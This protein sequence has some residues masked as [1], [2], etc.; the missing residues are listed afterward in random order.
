MTMRRSNSWGLVVMMAIACGGDDDSGTS[1]ATAAT[2]TG[3]ESSSGPATT[4]ESTNGTTNATTVGT[5][6]GTTM[7]DD[8]PAD[9]G[10]GDT[11]PADTGPADT[12]P[13]DTGPADTG[14]VETSGG[15]PLDN[16]LMMAADDCEECACNNC[17]MQLMACQADEG[18]TAIR[19][20]AQ[21][22][23]C[24]GLA[25]LGPCGGPIGMYPDSVPLAMALSDCYEGA[26]PGC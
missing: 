14:P 21:E 5:S 23:D 16:C 1:N 12:G 25:C 24:T 15:G 17:L 9:T 26:C 20:C 3:E 10:P 2:T 18:C 8:G 6:M 11:G 4:A 22:N 7:T 13:A 19:M